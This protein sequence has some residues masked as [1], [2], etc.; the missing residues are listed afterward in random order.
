M[1]LLEREK[2]K[3]YELMTR[4]DLLS[5]HFECWCLYHPSGTESRLRIGVQGARIE[6]EKTSGSSI[7]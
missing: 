1:P 2:E 4:L 3:K 7:S 5:E 6:I